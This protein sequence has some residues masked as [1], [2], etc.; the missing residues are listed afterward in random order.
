MPL[1]NCDIELDLRWTEKCVISEISRPFRAVDDPPE[2]EVATT[3]TG[4]TF[5]RNNVKL[6]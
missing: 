2:Q 5:Q 3:T 4:A 1:I 6:C